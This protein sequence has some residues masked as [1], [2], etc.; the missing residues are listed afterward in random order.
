LSHCALTLM[1]EGEAEGPDGVVRPAAEL[2]AEPDTSN[3]ADSVH[4]VI[5]AP[6]PAPHRPARAATAGAAV[7]AGVAAGALVVAGGAVLLWRR[8]RRAR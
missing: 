6:P 1:G 5:A 4:F 2:L 3:N 8:S 7:T